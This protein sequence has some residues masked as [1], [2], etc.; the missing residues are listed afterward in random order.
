MAL[1][2][3]PGWR[4]AEDRSARCALLGRAGKDLRGRGSARDP[5]KRQDGDGVD[6]KGHRCPG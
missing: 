3:L 5:W 2:E 1:H 4:E 6:L